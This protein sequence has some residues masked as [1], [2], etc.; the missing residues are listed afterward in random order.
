[1]SNDVIQRMQQPQRA[2][3]VRA[4]WHPART[5]PAKDAIKKLERRVK[6]DEMRLEKR[7]EKLLGKKNH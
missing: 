2:Q 3:H 5:L 4:A 7:S 1:M 6:S